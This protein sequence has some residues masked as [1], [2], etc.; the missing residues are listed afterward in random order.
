MSFASSAT[1][2]STPSANSEPSSG[3]TIDFKVAAPSVFASSVALTR[4]IGLVPPRKTFSVTLPKS[5][6]FIPERPWVAMVTSVPLSAAA[7]SMIICSALPFS[8]VHF[9]LAPGNVPAIPFRYCSTVPHAIFNHGIEVTGSV[10]GDMGCHFDNINDCQELYGK[11]QTPREKASVGQY[12]FSRLRS[13]Q[14]YQYLRVH[15]LLPVSAI[16]LRSPPV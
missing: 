13:V 12:F 10:S 1:A 14:R 6:R 5:H 15:S 8:N 11:L 9:V 4:S 16:A 2:G 3:T 7:A